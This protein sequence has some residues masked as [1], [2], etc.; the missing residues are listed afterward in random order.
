MTIFNKKFRGGGQ[1][2]MKFP[3]SQA[4]QGEA[5][6]PQGQAWP[7]KKI[8]GGGEIWWNFYLPLSL[9]GEGKLSS[10]G[11]NLPPPFGF[12]C[13]GASQREANYHQGQ[14]WQNENFREG[15]GYIWWNFYLLL[16]L[17]GAGKLSPGGGN[18]PPTFLL[19][20]YR[21]T[22]QGKGN[23]SQGQAQPNKKIQE[24]EMHRAAMNKESMY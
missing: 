5:N 1:N 8:Q 4:S 21:G 6:Y 2:S 23:Y 18:L 17:S 9:S 10:G 22:S 13:T 16:S 15:G 24:W 3:P 19:L 14:A 7:H 12:Y 20:L 11:G